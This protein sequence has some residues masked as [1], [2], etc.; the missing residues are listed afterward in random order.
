M[1][2]E[3]LDLHPTLITLAK[4]DRNVALR[5]YV[6]H[7]LGS[8]GSRFVQGLGGVSLRKAAGGHYP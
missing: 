8:L 4:K 6:R 1:E 7:R 5:K 2:P 3:E